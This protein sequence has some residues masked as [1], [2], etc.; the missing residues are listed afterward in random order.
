[1][2]EMERSS[3]KRFRKLVSRV[4]PEHDFQERFP[5]DKRGVK[6]E[7]SRKARH[8]A[9]FIARQCNGA[10]VPWSSVGTVVKLLSLRFQSSKNSIPR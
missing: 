6:A 5:E 1:M 8:C 4:V 7:L 10:E 3:S 2:A 9:R